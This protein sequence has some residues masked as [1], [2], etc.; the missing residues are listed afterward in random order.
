MTANVVRLF[1]RKVHIRGAAHRE[2][3]GAMNSVN[4]LTAVVILAFGE[5][6]TFAMRDLSHPDAIKPFDL[7]SRAGALM[8][9]EKM[10]YLD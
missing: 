4:G 9:R 1:P 5:D 6:G 3:T 8:E 2:L 10:G 7:Y